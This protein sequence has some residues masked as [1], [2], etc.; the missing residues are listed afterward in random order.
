MSEIAM[1]VD[2]RGVTLDLRAVLVWI[3]VYAFMLKRM[4]LLKQEGKKSDTFDQDHL[5]E[6]IESNGGMTILY[7][8]TCPCLGCAKKII[9]AGVKQVIYHEEYGMD[10]FTLKLFNEAGVKMR[11]YIPI[12]DV[13]G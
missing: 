4:L 11:Q 9:Q 12:L 13:V 7:C 3:N 2:V 8:S 10:A 1:K 5:R 6:R